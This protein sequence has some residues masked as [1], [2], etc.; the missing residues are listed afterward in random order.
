MVASSAR[1]IVSRS[2]V[3]GNSAPGV[4]PASMMSRFGC[5]RSVSRPATWGIVAFR[6]SLSKATAELSVS[7]VTSSW[8]MIR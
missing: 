2:P 7:E 8:R 1:P 6:S 4:G 5:E 3:S